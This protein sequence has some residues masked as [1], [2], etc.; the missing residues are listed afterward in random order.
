MY[1]VSPHYKMNSA[2]TVLV[3]SLLL[4]FLPPGVLILTPKLVKACELKHSSAGV[5]GS[6]LPGSKWMLQ[7]LP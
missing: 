2:V 7:L 3:V 6:A 4:L 5:K 1:L